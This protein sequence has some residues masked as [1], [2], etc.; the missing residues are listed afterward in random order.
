MNFKKQNIV[1]LIF[2]IFALMFF[3]EVGLVWA[4]S[5]N[6]NIANNNIGSSANAGGN[7]GDDVS[8]NSG[9]ALNRVINNISNNLNERIENKVKTEIAVRNNDSES[10][11]DKN[12]ETTGTVEGAVN[13]KKGLV[14]RVEDAIGNIFESAFDNLISILK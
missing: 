10:I 2:L 6:A 12:R 14:C 1:T 3:G 11:S 7:T 5:S 4:E 13:E 8:A 9:S